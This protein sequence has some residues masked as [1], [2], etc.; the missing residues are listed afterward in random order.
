MSTETLIYDITRAVYRRLGENASP[1]LVEDL[2]TDVYRALQPALQAHAV[3]PSPVESAPSN[4]TRAVIS[5]FGNDGI[6]IAATILNVLAETRCSL[7][8]IDQTIL[9]GKFAMVLIA[10]TTS[11]DL[12][13]TALREK[14]EKVGEKLDVKIYVQREDLF[15][16]MHRV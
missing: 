5:V 8:D 7:V 11:A 4:Q 14:L 12:S 10:D 9:R 15:H 16:A 6:G 13:I 2:V 3:T 1:A